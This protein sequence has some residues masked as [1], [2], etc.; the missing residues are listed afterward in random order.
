MDQGAEEEMIDEDSIA[1]LERLAYSVREAAKV[2][3]VSKQTLYRNERDGKITFQKVGK[4]TFVTRTELLRFLTE[5]PT[6]K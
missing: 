6:M 4:R 3:G 1:P 5:S 2:I